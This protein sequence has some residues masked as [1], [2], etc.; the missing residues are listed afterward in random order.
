M[1]ED[2][3][4]ALLRKEPLPGAAEAKRRGLALVERAYAERR[5][6]NRPVLPRLAVALAAAALLAAL[7]LSPAGAAVR[8]WIG[9]VFT[10]GVRNARPALTEVPGGGRLLVQSSR[11]PWVV[12]PDGS[13]R[14]L[15]RYEEAS[16]SPHGLF[17]AAA[18]GRTLSAIEPG[19]TPHWSISAAGP[20]SDPRWSPSGFRIA[21]RAGHSLHAIKADGTGDHL[22]GQAAPIAPAWF[23]LGTHLLAYV[24]RARQL[25]I[26]ETDT[27]RTLAS[28]A[29]TAGVTTL[30]WSADGRFLLELTPH[31]LWLRRLRLDKLADRIRLGAA[32]RVPLPAGVVRAAAFAPRRHTIAVLLERRGGAGAP[33]SEALLIDAGGGPPRRLFAVS[34]RL[35]QLAWSPDGSRLLLA[36]PA[37]DQWLFLPVRQ[38]DHLRAIGNIASVF[39]PGHAGA[40]QLPQIEGWC[41]P[42]APSGSG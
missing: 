32:R 8:S 28:T 42:P 39:S 19:G 31:G 14:L 22:L 9:D 17:L 29:A 10:A 15:G 37:A 7:L 41:C 30:G 5:S 21:Y 24:D 34:G 27:S 33:H 25:R 4:R 6:A 2:R 3:L 16:W 13:R 23:Q 12:Q 20:V 18:S 40:A 36:W 11:G 1:S 35:S 26:A 38:E